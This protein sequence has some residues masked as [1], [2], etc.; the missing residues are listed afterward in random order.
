MSIQK[1]RA[2][3]ARLF[4]AR[5]RPDEKT[6]LQTA[7]ANGDAMDAAAAPLPETAPVAA[8]A[9][10]PVAGEAG[11]AP[12]TANQEF[13]LLAAVEAAMRTW[14][15][16]QRPEDSVPAAVARAGPDAALPPVAAGVSDPALEAAIAA[17]SVPDEAVMGEFTASPEPSPRA[18]DLLA[19][20]VELPI[21]AES[22]TPSAAMIEAGLGD[23]EATG[24]SAEAQDPVQI[25]DEPIVATVDAIAT[26][27]APVE[28]SAAAGMGAASPTFA[29]PA[30]LSPTSEIAPTLPAAAGAD[31]APPSAAT[32]AADATPAV[33]PTAPAMPEAAAAPAA[34]RGAEPSPAAS[35]PDPASRSLAPPVFPPMSMSLP[36]VATMSPLQIVS[37]TPAQPRP[38]T[39][40]APLRQ[41]LELAVQVDGGL[42]AGVADIA[43]GANLATAGGGIDVVAAASGLATVLR[44]KLKAIAL[45]RLAEPLEDVVVTLGTQLHLLR[46]VD[47]HRFIWVVL[48]R[49]TANLALARFR[50]SEAADLLRA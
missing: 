24:D 10:A 25:Q 29:H 15:P 32:I 18:V 33:T 41:A 39:A 46:M 11:P 34:D 43:G 35:D 3:G 17:L 16:E 48:D 40:E 7:P 14:S 6:I 28:L 49:S 47:E 20:P 38:A 26:I 2:F 8:P 30:V 1:R 13:D 4:G 31:V 12:A 21:E 9:I 5:S 36:K 44:T 50:A 23:R 37:S 19:P 45:L 42:A 22:P 27:P